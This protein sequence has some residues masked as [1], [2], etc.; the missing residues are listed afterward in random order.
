MTRYELIIAVRYL[1]A[2]RKRAH[3]AFLSLISTLGLAVGVA[4]LLISL[5]LL[6]GLQGQIKQRLIAASP[7]L[8]IE[9]TGSNTI[10]DSAAVVAAAKAAGLSQIHQ[11][12]TGIAWGSD[13]NGGRGEPARIRSF[14]QSS[15]PRAEE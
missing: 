2:S 3:T 13:P 8:L 10:G 12:I 9:P 14:D 11:V 6:S 4:T 1:W 7:R 5:A 15:V